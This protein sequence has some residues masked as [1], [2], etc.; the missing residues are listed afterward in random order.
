MR[1]SVTSLLSILVVAL[2]ACAPSPRP[3]DAQDAAAA[4]AGPAE[5]GSFLYVP[6]QDDA[7]ISVVELETLEVVET[8]DLQ[9][10]GFGPNA[11]PHHVAVEPD[12]SYWYLT[13]IGANRVVKF[14][15][16][17]QVV[18]QAELE[19]PGMVVLHPTEDRM[20]VGR[21]MSAVNPPQ[22]IGVL[23]RSGLEVEQA[24]VFF[25]RPHAVALGADGTWLYVGS[26]AVNQIASLIPAEEEIELLDIDGPQHTLV[27]FAVSPDGQWLVATGEMTGR[28]LVFDLSDPAAPRKVN[29]V[30]V[31]QRPWHPVF[32][33]DGSRLFFG[34]KDSNTVSVLETDGWGVVETLEPEGLDRPHGAAVSP[35]G[36]RVFISS[37]GSDGEPG[38]VTVIDA[39]TLEVERVIPVGRNAAGLG[40]PAVR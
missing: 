18:G 9:A 36:R 35:D 6:N 40:A 8:V 23:T 11:K 5:P 17:N 39:E 15:A 16:D 10:L 27:Q 38:T 22:R 30:P 3:A 4:S 14:D 29:E 37:N 20:Y 1:R 24:D 32:T 31:G 34:N 12:G 13:L 26:L 7:T 25:P 28:L 33:P 21:S 2:A 19:V